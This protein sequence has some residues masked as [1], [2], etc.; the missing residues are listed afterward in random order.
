[1]LSA[2]VPFLSFSPNRSK[3]ISSASSSDLSAQPSCRGSLGIAKVS[4]TSLIAL[5]CEQK[6]RLQL[7]IGLAVRFTATTSYLA[8][9]TSCTMDPPE[10]IWN[11]K[12]T[13]EFSNSPE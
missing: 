7:T 13:L 3:R 9:K 8:A 6:V 4:G 1:M 12:S 2:L 11:N 10:L 5:P